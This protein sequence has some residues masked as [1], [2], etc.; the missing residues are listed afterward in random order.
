[1]TKE[2]QV[3]EESDRQT[4]LRMSLSGESLLAREQ[5]HEQAFRGEDIGRGT[6]A[7]HRRH[8]R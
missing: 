7:Y 5:G 1:M 2:K 4:A 3:P 8:V 6:L